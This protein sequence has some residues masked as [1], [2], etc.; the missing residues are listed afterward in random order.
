[1]TAPN[2]T[3]TGLT[4]AGEATATDAS[5]T[6]IG[7]KA[8]TSDSLLKINIIFSSTNTQR[9][10]RYADIW[11][12]SVALFKAKDSSFLPYLINKGT[13]YPYQ[14]YQK[15]TLGVQANGVTAPFKVWTADYDDHGRQ[16]NVA[17][18]EHNDSLKNV[19]YQKRG[20]ID[21]KWNPDSSVNGSGDILIIFKSTYSDTPNVRYTGPAGTPLLLKTALQGGLVDPMYYVW[22]RRDG[23]KTFKDGD[24]LTI[25]PNYTLG[26][27]RHYIYTVPTTVIGSDSIAKVTNAISQVNVFPNPYYAYNALE[28]NQFVHFV[29]F[30]HLPR[31]CTIRIFSLNGVLLKTIQHVDATGGNPYERWDLT[32]ASSLPVASGM[33]IAYIDGGTV[34]TK[35]LKLAVIQPQ[36]RVNKL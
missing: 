6:A 20:G 5:L 22:L 36:Q 19:L 8:V 18:L 9:V 28:T 11:N 17:L 29:T 10:Y 26:A 33:Y 7:A 21:G 3:G 2:D 34:G 1:M 13:G 15:Y 12:Q 23:A 30:T 32:N 4:W 16:L 24:T 35:I 25:T 31:Q 27:G 14:D